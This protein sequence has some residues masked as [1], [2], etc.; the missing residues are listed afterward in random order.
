MPN[1]ILTKD[2]WRVSFIERHEVVHKSFPTIEAA[3]ALMIEL[4]VK[5]QAIDDAVIAIYTTDS[6]DAAAVFHSDG[7]FAFLDK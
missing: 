2:G 5:D 4:G 7:R 6:K 1:L 3:A